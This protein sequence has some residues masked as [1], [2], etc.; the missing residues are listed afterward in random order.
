[1]AYIRC[2]SSSRLVRGAPLGEE[3][4]WP[5]ASKS[6]SHAVAAI[7]SVRSGRAF[8]QA[9]VRGSHSSPRSLRAIPCR[10]QRRPRSKRPVTRSRPRPRPPRR[11][12][13]RPVMRSRPRPRRP[14][15]RSRPPATRSRPP[16][17]RRW[18]RSKRPVTRSHHARLG[19]LRLIRLSL[20]KPP[21]YHPSAPI[22]TPKHPPRSSP[23]RNRWSRPVTMYVKSARP[24]FHPGTS[25][26]VAAEPSFHL[27]FS[28]CAPISSARCKRPARR[29]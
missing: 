4:A 22:F 15:R 10:R 1:M 12:L 24:R 2:R 6:E 9:A 3:A 7:R 5:W 21:P 18:R 25:S 19:P 8:V 11:R 16:R 29:A 28:I 20:R 14:R 23:R 26:A 27:R 13:R 17:L